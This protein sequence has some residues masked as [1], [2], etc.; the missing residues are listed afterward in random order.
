MI[1]VDSKQRIRNKRVDGEDAE[2]HSDVEDKNGDDDN[3]LGENG[4]RGDDEYSDTTPSEES[5]IGDAAPKIDEDGG[6]D[7]VIYDL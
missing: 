4:V 6:E 7:G 1:E 2:E 5:D 3:I